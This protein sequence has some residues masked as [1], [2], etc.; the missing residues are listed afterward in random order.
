MLNQEKMQRITQRAAEEKWS[1]PKL[2]N[3][4]KK[5]GIERYE[6]NVLT[7]EIKYVGDGGSF[8]TPAPVGFQPLTAGPR[9]DEAA[10]KAALG[11]VQRQETNYVQ[12]LGE[13]AAAGVAFYRVDMAPRT[14]TYHGPTPREKLVEK[15][16]EPEA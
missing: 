1:Y 10:L 3:A 7:H 11:R 9:Y 8:I 14:V 5:M 6:T 2:F 13:I 16:P 4:L 15:V 12:F